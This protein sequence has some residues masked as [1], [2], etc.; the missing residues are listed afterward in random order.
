M[1]VMTQDAAETPLK[2]ITACINSTEM[3]EK[4]DA[5]NNC[6]KNIVR[7]NLNSSYNEQCTIP[8]LEQKIKEHRNAFTTTCGLRFPNTN[9][10]NLLEYIEFSLSNDSF[11]EFY[12]DLD[13][14]K[15]FEKNIS[16]CVKSIV[17]YI[18]ISE[19]AT[20]SSFNKKMDLAYSQRNCDENNM[21]KD[22]VLK[23]LRTCKPSTSKYV[24]SLFD[25]AHSKCSNLTIKAEPSTTVVSS[26]PHHMLF[27]FSVIFGGVSSN[28]AGILIWIR[29]KTH[30]HSVSYEE[31]S[32]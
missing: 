24:T 16:A 12:S 18:P 26:S 22:C 10:T 13:C 29:K 28:V 11:K 27:I 21:V 6:F 30:F 7:K 4:R 19:K 1:V 32:R 2:N 17:G 20:H 9:M 15:K 3:K 8:E 5:I 25:F 14:V 23:L 31:H